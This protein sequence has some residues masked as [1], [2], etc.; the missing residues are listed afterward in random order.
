MSRSR[1]LIFLVARRE[2]LLR[3]RSRAFRI[4]TIAMVALIAVGIVLF[5]ALE[6][7]TTV[8]VAHVG[9][10]GTATALEPDFKAEAAAA[11]TPVTVSDVADATAGTAQVDAGT[12]DVLV[13][14]EPTAPGAVVTDTVPPEVE[15]ALITAVLEARLAAVG[16]T[17]ATVVSVVDGTNVVV[18]PRKPSAAPDPQRTGELLGALA[19]AILLYISLGFYGSSVAQGVVEEKAT[20]MVEILLATMRPSQLLA[21]KVL[22]I[23]FVGLLQLSIVGAATLIIV[24]MTHA[25]ALPALGPLAVVGDLVWFT[26]GFLFYALAFAALAATVSRQEEAASATAPMNVFLVLGYLLVFLVLPNPGNA[27][28][29]FVSLLPPFA[30]VLMSVRIA[31]GDAQGWQVVLAMALLIASIGGLI[32]LAGRMYANSVLRL[33]KRVRFGDAFRGH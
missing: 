32:W 10:V 7:A 33:G 13:T 22:G 15:S 24:A 5:S 1:R 30:P 2:I 20:R 21:G 25:V 9:F 27:F 8:S 14:G 3:L 17:P 28:S 31:T 11:G 19:V 29:A 4:G 12:L 16:L 26:L 6:P 18:Q 23:G